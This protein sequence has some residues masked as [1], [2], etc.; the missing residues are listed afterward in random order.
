MDHELHPDPA[1][2]AGP[3]SQPWMEP[4]GAVPI[5]LWVGDLDYHHALAGGL[6]PP[7]RVLDA[8]RLGET[9]HQLGCCAPA[10]CSRSGTDP[11]RDG[12]LAGRIFRVAGSS[13]GTRC[14]SG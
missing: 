2:L 9:F 8:A 6:A 3:R 7:A 10:G 1:S 4:A 14:R 13:A 11:A 12:L 5:H